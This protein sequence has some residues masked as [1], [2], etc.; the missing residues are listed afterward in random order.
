MQ[1]TTFC[2]ISSHLIKL[3]LFL[4]NYLKQI[5]Y[6]G[7]ITIPENILFYIFLTS[8]SFFPFVF[9]FLLTF[10]LLAIFFSLSFIFRVFSPP[11]LTYSTCAMFQSIIDQGKSLSYWKKIRRFLQLLGRNFVNILKVIHPLY[12]ILGDRTINP[13]KLKFK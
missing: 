11:L 5:I 12:T 3:H 10:L 4:W 6:D 7:S 1:V 2:K 13:I 9:T 8:S